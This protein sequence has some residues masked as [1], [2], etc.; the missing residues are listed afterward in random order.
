M[1]TQNTSHICK[2]I[3]L[4]CFLGSLN[5][6]KGCNQIYTHMCIGTH[7]LKCLT[8]AKQELKVIICGSF[9]NL[10][11]P[12]R[13]QCLIDTTLTPG[14][15]HASLKPQRKIS[16][17]HLQNIVETLK[18]RTWCLLYILLEAQQSEGTWLNGLLLILD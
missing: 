14:N 13:C 8:L 12:F 11:K 10:L 15:A 1:Y 3:M 7:T 16:D 6:H 4:I 9:K 2:W 17:F 18:C 5:R